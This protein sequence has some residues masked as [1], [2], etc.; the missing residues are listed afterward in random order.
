M[1]IVSGTTREGD[2]RSIAGA[3]VRCLGAERV[4]GKTPDSSCAAIKAKGE[5]FCRYCAEKTV[6]FASVTDGPVISITGL[7]DLEQR[8]RQSVASW[9][10]T[11]LGCSWVC[12]AKIAQ[13]L[14]KPC[15][16]PITDEPFQFCSAPTQIVFT[17]HGEL[18][19]EPGQDMIKKT[20][21]EAITKGD[22][23]I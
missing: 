8:R 3:I 15:K 21:A 7:G 6:T 14:G 5:R 10:I 19:L 12:S 23:I 2:R 9:I 22:C 16:R 17:E 13:Q 1:I 18:Y 11:S 4:C 20:A